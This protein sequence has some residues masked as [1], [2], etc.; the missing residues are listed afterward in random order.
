ME[1]VKNG[2]IIKK[3]GKA[4]K[5]TSENPTLDSLRGILENTSA[6]ELEQS[7]VPYMIKSVPTLMK[8]IFK[9]TTSLITT[10]TQ[11]TILATDNPITCIGEEYKGIQT[12][13]RIQDW[14]LNET[15]IAFTYKSLS[16]SDE[17]DDKVFCLDIPAF[18]HVFSNTR[19]LKKFIID[20]SINLAT[21][22]NDKYDNDDMVGKRHYKE[23][24]ILLD[25]RK[26][27]YTK[28][29]TEL[30]LVGTTFNHM[31]SKQN[32][33]KNTTCR[34]QDVYFQLRYQNTKDEKPKK[35]M[36]ILS[37]NEWLEILNNED[38][39]NFSK[40]LWDFLPLTGNY[41]KRIESYAKIVLPENLTPD[42]DG[43]DIESDCITEE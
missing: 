7:Y 29:Y 4:S 20:M 10:L 34:P 24:P 33:Y 19:E 17:Q 31:L 3:V 37:R 2:G 42:C 21:E 36:F 15:L 1:K 11:I 16:A 27:L 28:H 43:D 41:S 35:G 6:E 23:F 8:D 12:F 14:P 40:E 38:F 18:N 25:Y 9:R 5:K 26:N 13:K 30:L 32:E 39:L 22:W